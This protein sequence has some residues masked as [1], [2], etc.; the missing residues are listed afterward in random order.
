MDSITQGLLGAVTAQ[1]GFRQK[2]G[3]DATWVAAGAAIVPD[4]DILV[5]PFL[6]LTGAEVDSTTSLMIHRGLSHSLLMMPVLSLPIATIWWWFRGRNHRRSR[7]DAAMAPVGAERPPRFALLYACVFVAVL[8]HPLLDWC[9]SYGTQLL[10]PFSHTRYAVD[11]I[12]IVDLIYSPLLILTLLACYLVRKIWRSR[13]MRASLAIGWIG[14]AL[15]CGYLVAGRVMHD[16]VVERAREAVNGEQVVQA[17]AYPALGTIFLWRAVVET[18]EEWITMRI[19]CFDRR[20]A[21]QWCRQ[22]AEKVENEWVNKARSLPVARTYLWF[23]GHRTRSQYIRQ[24]G[25]HEV[26]L[27]DMRYGQPLESVESI[28]PL[29]VIFN[30][31]GEVIH[32]GPHRQPR[33]ESFGAMASRAWR[34]MLTVAPPSGPCIQGRVEGA[35]NGA[36][37]QPAGAE[38]IGEPQFP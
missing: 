16:Y 12:A 34:D 37:T 38:S 5:T 7:R 4:L 25:H 3:R 9:T 36:E 23:N 31:R 33:G 6:A 17:D 15:S 10:A 28:W 1:L 29:T 8:T 21:D 27:H 2:I 14:F 22:H 35:H 26:L 30:P 13:A 11:A 24:N 19:H 18:P 32:T 20:P